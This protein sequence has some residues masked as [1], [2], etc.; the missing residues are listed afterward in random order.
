MFGGAQ[1]GTDRRTGRPP[2][3]GRGGPCVG[4]GRRL[5]VVALEEVE[6]VFVAELRGDVLAEALFE[7]ALEN[8]HFVCAVEQVWDIRAV[9]VSAECDGVLSAKVEPV[10]NV[11]GDLIERDGLARLALGA[12]NEEIA[13]VVETNDATASASLGKLGVCEVARVVADS[14]GI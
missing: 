2:R 3:F 14:A 12:L 13:A 10:L 1:A 9:K 4:Y 6:G 8:G 5:T 11:G 7:Q